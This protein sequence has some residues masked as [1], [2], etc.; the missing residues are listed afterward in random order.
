[1]KKN[2]Q[3]GNKN[4]VSLKRRQNNVAMQLATREEDHIYYEPKNPLVINE[5]NKVLEIFV[6]RDEEDE[7]EEVASFDTEKVIRIVFKDKDE[8][9]RNIVQEFNSEKVPYSIDIHTYLTLDEFERALSKCNS[10]EEIEDL[11]E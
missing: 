5:E 6:K 8:S 7:Y 9:E 10:E 3:K 4:G 2:F 1:M 11:N